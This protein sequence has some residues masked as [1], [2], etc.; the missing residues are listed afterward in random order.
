MFPKKKRK[1]QKENIKCVRHTDLAYYWSISSAT[2]HNPTFNESYPLDCFN[3]HMNG[4]N[5]ASKKF[6]SRGLFVSQQNLEDFKFPPFIIWSLYNNP[7]NQIHQHR[8]PIS[9][10][11]P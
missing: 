5:R 2:D 8:F 9:Q 3:I 1:N 7:P 11:Q 4:P 10:E 6:E